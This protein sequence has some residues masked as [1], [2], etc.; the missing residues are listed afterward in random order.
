MSWVGLSFVREGFLVAVA[1][2]LRASVCVE[3]PASDDVGLPSS[4]RAVESGQHAEQGSRANAYR[5]GG[6][7]EIG[8]CWRGGH[9]CNSFKFAS[10][11][12]RLL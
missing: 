9:C 12:V 4:R 8:V 6:Q 3:T 7:R 1:V 11:V 2:G 10:I 5:I